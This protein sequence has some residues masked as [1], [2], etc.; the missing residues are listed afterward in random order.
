MNW[1][2]SLL[3]LVVIIVSAAFF[4]IASFFLGTPWGKVKALISAHYYLENT[5]EQQM[6]E[7]CVLYDFKSEV[8]VVFV[9]PKNNKNI[10]FRVYVED[11]GDVWKETYYK[12]Y[13]SYELGEE[14]NEK[15]QQIFG[16]D[17][18]ACARLDSETINAYNLENLN[19]NTKLEDIIAKF[20]N[21]YDLGVKI[22][23]EF[24]FSDYSAEAEKILEFINYV[25]SLEYKPYDVY[26]IYYTNGR[27]LYGGDFRLRLEQDEYENIN[28]VQ[29][30]L[31]YIIVF[32]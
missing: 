1:K 19:E 13:F 12:V 7:K 2:I 29:D 23:R 27:N 31:P 3:L 14:A 24:D 15:V 25:N 11:N 16:D 5:Y 17:N 32:K 4:V 21:R 9:I 30:L 18:I 8:Y 26:F 22:Y 28:C 6:N 20:D 10:C